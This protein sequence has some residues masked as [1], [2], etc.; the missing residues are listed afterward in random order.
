MSRNH[1]IRFVIIFIS[2][3]SLASAALLAD[4]PANKGKSGKGK[5][6]AQSDWGDIN[7]DLGLS[8]MLTAG[9]SFGDARQ[10][11]VD[12]SLT[13]SK[14]LPPGIRKNLARGKPMPPGIAKTRMP[15]AFISQLPQYDGYEWQQAG[16]DLVLVV[17]GSLVISDLLEG[18]FD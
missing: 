15:D 4:P 1:L 7:V 11:A 9:I 16:S 6:E 14:P 17:T 12:N 5:N 18:I 3:L 10:L 8:A 13:G 2:A